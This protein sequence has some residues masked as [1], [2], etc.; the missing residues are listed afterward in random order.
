MA[1]AKTYTAAIFSAVL[2]TAAGIQSRAQPAT[3]G[4]ELAPFRTGAAYRHEKG[5]F[6]HS[7]SIGGDLSGALLKRNEKIG[8]YSD[9]SCTLP[10]VMHELKESVFGFYAGPGVT[11][12]LCDDFGL[13]MGLILGP[14][15]DLRTEFE[16]KRQP[17]VLSLGVKPSLAFHTY[18]DL[19]TE[20]LC[21]GIYKQGLLNS[22]IPYF[23]VAYRFDGRSVSGSEP[24]ESPQKRTFN[25]AIEADYIANIRV[26]SHLNYITDEGYRVNEEDNSPKYN[27]NAQVLAGAGVNIGRH[28]NLSLYSGYQGINRKQALIPVLLRPSVLLGQPGDKGRWL[29]FIDGGPGFRASSH[30]DRVAV[31]SH[32][33]FGYRIAT[34]KRTS[35]DILGSIHSTVWHPWFF[36][37]TVK[38]VRRN[39]EVL[40]GINLGVAVI[41]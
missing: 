28:F 13:P 18:R 7:V 34:T 6:V 12:G 36:D 16:S 15:A 30:A 17:I 11:L 10:I 33:G 40:S 1:R 32:A 29:V 38:E 9:Y 39:N 31:I 23:G 3:V 2:L 20:Q 21:M 41:L 24:A 14:M 25:F 22:L 37:D 27:T 19:E 8:L 5:H 26:Y 35:L 4:A